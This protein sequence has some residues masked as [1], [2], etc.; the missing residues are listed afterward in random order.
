MLRYSLTDEEPVRPK[1]LRFGLLSAEEIAR[2]S[3]V[4]VT[5]TMLYYRGLPATGSLMDPVMG[6]VD[7]R[8]LCVTCMRPARTCPGH[9]G[10]LE[11]S[12]PVYHYSYIET[13]LKLLRVTCFHC[14]RVCATDDEGRGYESL[15]AEALEEDDYVSAGRARLNALHALLRGRKT[16]PHCGARRPSYARVPLGI[17]M[18]WP[19]DVEW[20]SQ[21]EEEYCKTPFTAREALS[22]LT[23][24]RDTDVELLGFHAKHS[25]PRNLIARNLVVPP[26]CARPAIYSSEGSRSRGQNDMTVRL[27]EIMRRSQEVASLLPEG[28][29]WRTQQAHPSKEMLDALTRLQY[30]VFIMVSNAARVHRPHGMS[31]SAGSNTA[32]SLIDRI[33]GKEGRVRGNLM[34]KRVDFSA[35]CVITP[36]AYFDIDRVGVPYKV[37]LQLTFPERVNTFNRK[38]LLARVRTGAG[39]VHGA[40]SIV[41]RDGT[42]TH[43]TTCSERA[44]LELQDGD[45]VERYLSD[46]DVVVFNRQPS[47]HL[48]GMVAHRVRL[49]PG[50]TFRLALPVAG[51][52]NADFDGDEMN[53]HLP[54]SRGAMAECAALMSVSQAN[55]IGA[56]ANKPVMGVVQDCLLGLFLLTH[57]RVIFRRQLLCRLLGGTRHACKDTLPVPAVRVWRAG[58]GKGGKGGK[59]GG[60]WECWW[61][62]K[63][64][65]SCLLPE[66]L[67]ISAP[68]LQ[69]S[70]PRAAGGEG[71]EEGAGVACWVETSEVDHPLVVL[72]GHLFAGLL[73]KANMGTSAG[74]IIDRLCRDVSNVACV[75]FMGDVQRLTHTYLMVRGH[76]VG[77]DHVM[78][79]QEG[80]ESVNDRLVKATQLCEE[81][82]SE[83]ALSTTTPEAAATAEGAIMRML[84]KMLLQTGSI[85]NEHMRAQNAIRDMVSAGSKGSFI[86][87]GQ[88]CGSLGQQSLE[89]SR[90][91]EGKGVRTLPCFTHDDH[92]LSSRGMV[93]HSFALGLSPSELF[94]H[95][96]GGREGL[97]DTAVKTSATGYLQ[98]RL[99]KTM[100]DNRVFND[101]TVRN[102]MREVISFRWGSDGMHPCHMERLPLRLLVDRRASDELPHAARVH[103]RYCRAQVLRC[104]THV[105]ATELDARVLLPFNPAVVRM[106]MD[107]EKDREENDREE[108]DR[109]DAFVKEVMAYSK[110]LPPA[111]ALAVLETFLHPCPR[112]RARGRGGPSISTR[113]EAFQTVRIKVGHAQS[114]CA[115]SVGCL[116]AQCIGEP[117]T[118]LTLN[119]FHTA[120]VVSRNVVLGVPRLKELLDVTK[121]PKTPCTTLRFHAE[122]AKDA[123]VAEYFANTLPLIRLGDLVAHVRMGDDLCVT[124]E[125]QQDLMRK[126]HLTPPI[127]RTHLR[128]RLLKRALV[129]SSEANELE[130]QVNITF[131]DI[132]EM[133]SYGKIAQEQEFILCH[134]AIKVLL[135]T[136]AI[137]GHDGIKAADAAESARLDANGKAHEEHVV[138][139]AGNFLQDCSASPCV[140]WTRC[141]SNNLCEVLS[142]LGVEACAHVL[143]DQ[144]RMVLDAYIDP[145]H[146]MLIVDTMCRRGRLMPLNRHGINRTNCSPLMRCSF[147]ETMDILSDAAIFS[148]QENAL[149]VT[150]SIMMGQLAQLGTGTVKVQL[151]LP[152]PTLKVPT[153]K[154]DAVRVLRS[155]I[156]SFVPPPKESNE[157]LEYVVDDVRPFVLPPKDASARRRTFRCVSPERG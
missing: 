91:G 57:K 74:G 135:D 102:A 20:G 89:G 53:L 78:L 131:F 71:G 19:A 157:V 95:C 10:H 62:G 120:G 121:Q 15:S 100:E 88:I 29:T 21:E 12:W 56:Q 129:T 55:S 83:V 132:H 73:R 59:G 84:S 48:H 34:G 66:A 41:H 75:R 44:S 137:S 123:W 151:P 145:R 109:E 143:Y 16:C 150:S 110:E 31:R 122:Y 11:L 64:A 85:V 2:M 154:K 82:Q 47:L 127:L 28:S 7:R 116:A 81:I 52:Y 117:T 105:L 113:K 8:H 30:E 35:R 4:K 115:E 128:Q 43:L 108:N 18:E 148:E 152:R 97:V 114:V 112:E 24:L 149:G 40:E 49:M 25:H 125:L 60:R 45:V 9:A 119:S 90:I 130:W 77:I 13:V 42:V 17:Q 72:R 133:V 156:R 37:A 142:I 146:I 67:T 68:S 98:R 86:N 33:K 101:G 153:S 94:F 3:V 39:H 6:S 46:D 124:L 32:K 27:L 38:T 106:R 70:P 50:H 138:H 51:P 92:R 141:T 140:D 79:S 76:H 54:Q 26:P 1:R 58:G 144:L 22:I 104:K 61:T 118:Q 155:T 80:Q 23:H 63:Q 14:A 5:D 65:F 147:E 87:L 136:M 139:V 107:Q 96:I 103:A 111:V 69:T 126:R 36:D 99:N 93:Y 134:R